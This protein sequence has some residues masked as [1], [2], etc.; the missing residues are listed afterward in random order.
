MVYVD[1]TLL[2]VVCFAIGW[3]LGR[4]HLKVKQQEDL[5]EMVYLLW[6]KVTGERIPVKTGILARLHRSKKREELGEL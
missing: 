4:I 2:G 1:E 6:E 5:R 3:I